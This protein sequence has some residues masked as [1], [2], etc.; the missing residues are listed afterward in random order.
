LNGFE[1][2]SKKIAGVAL[3]G[4]ELTSGNYRNEWSDWTE[5]KLPLPDFQY[6]LDPRWNSYFFNATFCS[7]Q[8][9]RNNWTSLPF[10]DI[11]IICMNK[12]ST[13]VD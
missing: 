7:S 5:W 4:K 3:R 6:S 13:K 10:S 12:C 2:S 11:R 8:S 9:Y 1:D